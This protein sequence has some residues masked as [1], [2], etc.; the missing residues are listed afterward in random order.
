MFPAPL[1]QS[2]EGLGVLLRLLG[3][4]PFAACEVQRIALLACHQATRHRPAV[5]P[6]Q[7]AGN[8]LQFALEVR[9][10]D[11]FHVLGIDT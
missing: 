7:L 9:Q 4:F 11:R 3:L 5:F 10:I 1:K 6:V 8:V 2:F